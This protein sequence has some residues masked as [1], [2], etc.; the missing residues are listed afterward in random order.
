MRH[1]RHLD[2]HAD[3]VEQGPGD[4][5]AV[6]P[7]LLRAA[8]AMLTAVAQMPAGAFLRCLFAKSE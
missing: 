8:M 2:L 7:H 3:T 1:W 6:T 5:I 4:A